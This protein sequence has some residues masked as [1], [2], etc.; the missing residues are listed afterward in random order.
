MSSLTFVPATE[1]KKKADSLSI[2]WA[3]PSLRIG[4]SWP[5]AVFFLDFWKVSFRGCMGRPDLPLTFV[6][7]V[8]SSLDVS[9]WYLAGTLA[10]RPTR[11]WLSSTLLPWLFPVSPTLSDMACLPS[12]EDTV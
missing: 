8:V 9:T 11:E 10:M 2:G 6:L 4:G 5:S 12:T 3:W 1:K 7:Q